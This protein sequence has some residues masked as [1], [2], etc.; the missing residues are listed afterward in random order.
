MSVFPNTSFI[1]IIYTK[2][3]TFTSR[4]ISGLWRKSGKSK[5]ISLFPE[6][7]FRRRP[8]TH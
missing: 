8:W 1:N 3:S 6:G 4:K 5:G 7:L 2:L